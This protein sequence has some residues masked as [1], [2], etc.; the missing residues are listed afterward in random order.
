MKKILLILCYLPLVAFGQNFHFSLRAGLASYRGDLKAKTAFIFS[1]SNLLGSI[2]ARYDLTEHLTARS[3]ITL[4]ALHADDKKGTASMRQRN[5][6]FKTK[7][8]DWEG[9]LQYNFFNL[10]YKWWTPYVYAGIGVFHF[11][12]YTKDTSGHKVF[13]RPLST[14]GEG[15]IP[16]VKE[17]KRTQFS[18]PF[19]VGADRAL[20]ED[21]RIGIEMGYR[22][23]FTDYIDDVSKNYVDQNALLAA[24]GATAV[25]LAYR[26]NEVGAG[27][28]PPAGAT[29]GSSKN[30]DGYFYIAITFTSRYF[31]DKYK[32]T[33]GLPAY[34]KEK[35]VGC[36]ASR[37]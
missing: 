30:K 31:F 32:Q 28:Y 2:G 19:G 26:G 17:Y 16:G 11:N 22:K 37:Y 18:I 14:E 20:N 4:T 29:R 21:M 13:L 12:P 24:R 36:P 33:A 9:G 7:I 1:Q 15:F 27:P 25:E 5:L 10:N 23:T 8:L 3:Y 35:K 34:K 6:N